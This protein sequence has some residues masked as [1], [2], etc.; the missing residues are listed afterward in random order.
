MTV[1]TEYVVCPVCGKN[2]PRL[3]RKLNLKA[4]RFSISDDIPLIY[5]MQG[6]GR[7]KG[8]EVTERISVSDAKHDPEYKAIIDDLISRM[9]RFIILAS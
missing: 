4:F 7:G 9:R 8:W 3:S 5:K 1:E 6:M 2:S